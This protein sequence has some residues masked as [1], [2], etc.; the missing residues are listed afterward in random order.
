MKPEANA[1]QVLAVTRS[2]AKMY[3]FDVPLEAHIALPQR[4]ELL[5]SLAVGLLGDAAASIAAGEAVAGR[6][7]TTHQ[8]LVFAATYFEAYNESRLDGDVK[9]DFS[10]LGAAAYYLADSPGSAVVVARWAEPPPATLGSG[11]ALLSYHLLLSNYG[12]ISPTAYQAY[13][14]R[15]LSAMASYLSGAGSEDDA[16]TLALTVREEAY[17]SGDGRELLYAD[18]VTAIVRKKITNSAR[19]IL[20]EASG[21]APEVWQPALERAAFPRELWP[22]QQRICTAGVLRGTSAIIQMPTSAGK[23]RATELILRSAFLS[24]RASLAV[25][26]CPFR[27]LCHDIRGDMARAFSGENVVLNEATDSFQQDLTVEALWEQRTILIVTPE[28]LLYLLRT[29]PELAQHIGLVIYDE[30]H[31]FDSGAR[32]VTYELLLTSLKLSLLENTQIVLISAVIANARN[33]AGWL[34]DDED[35]VVDG[36]GLLPTARRV[37][38]ASWLA[39]L[40]RLEYV[41]P[42]DPDDTEFFVPRVINRVLLQ[43]LKPRAKDEYFP[44]AEDGNSIGLYLGLKLVSKGSVAVFCGRKDTAVKIC[45]NAVEVFQRSDAFSRPVEQADPEEVQKLASLFSRQIGETASTTKAA[46]LGIFPHHASVP[47]GLRLSVEFAMKTNRINFVV[48]TS[49]LA[50]GVNLPIRYL[51]VTGVYQGGER[52]LVRDFHNLIGRA[53]RAGMHTEGSIIFADTKVFDKKRQRRERWRWRT[54]KQLLNPANSEPSSSSI[55]A[56]FGPFEFGDPVRRVRINVEVL[57][58]LV[59]DDDTAVE[60]TVNQM[61]ANTLGVPAKQ[62]RQFLRERVQIVHGI[63]SFLLAHLDFA[64]DG[65]A[66]RAVNLAKNTL[67]HYL[68]D[69]GQRAQFETVFQRIAERILAGAATEDSRATLRRSPL[70]PTTVNS[71]KAWLEASRGALTQAF[72]AGTLLASMSPVVL[73]YNRSNSITSVSDQTVMP[74]IIQ[75]WVTGATFATI[76]QFLVERNIRIGGNNRRPTVEDAVAICESGLGYEGAMI[77]ATI[78]DLAEGDDGE[79]PGALALLQQQLKCGLPSRAA[80]GFFEAGFADRVVAQTLAEAFPDVVDRQSARIAVR[81]SAAQTREVLDQFPSYFSS[82]LDELLT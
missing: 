26:V 25:I 10:I 39:Q 34:I 13:P 58:T 79:L 9:V 12:P 1:Q 45:A 41:S 31:Q 53:G 27:S 5:F 48:C 67:A 82:V 49:T 2:K 3:E 64:E 20:P 55:S 66:E 76:F 24:D 74:L 23:T 7:Q 56:I 30:G 42:L 50:Q 70:A 62:F 37:A 60:N 18:V 71:I 36:A 57:H 80:L 14:D 29:T 51:I 15:I 72:E 47:S 52:M 22:S 28:K 73:Q 6:E 40:G 8:S 68:A 43:K 21:L 46:E 54:A 61:I 44:R 63:V 69:E 35:A 17:R 59:F 11:L 75:Q 77:L 81:G 19:A 65:L 78:A 16:V 38:F 32:G 4:P 33:I